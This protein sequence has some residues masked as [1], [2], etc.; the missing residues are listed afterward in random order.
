MSIE[1][2]SERVFVHYVEKLH[3]FLKIYCSAKIEKMNLN[4]TRNGERLRLR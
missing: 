3:Q 1:E 4:V 2:E